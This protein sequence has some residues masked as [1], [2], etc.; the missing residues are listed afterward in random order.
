MDY[1]LFGEQNCHALSG[2][3]T[4]RCADLSTKPSTSTASIRTETDIHGT[5][6]SPDMLPCRYTPQLKELKA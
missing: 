3:D 2:Q 1:P 6:R 5:R 4:A